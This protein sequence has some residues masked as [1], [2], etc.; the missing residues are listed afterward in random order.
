MKHPKNIFIT[1]ATG[2]IG[3][4]LAVRFLERGYNLKL[5]VRERDEDINRRIDRI[6]SNLLS[7]DKYNRLKEKIEAIRGDITQEN[8]GIS[9]KDLARIVGEVRDVFHFAASVSFEDGNREVLKRQNV[10]GTRNVLEFVKKLKTTN[11]HYMSTAYVA[12]QR[13]GIVYEV[14]LDKGQRFNNFYEET[15]FEAEKLVR[16]YEDKYGINTIIY[17]PTVVVGDSNTGRTSNFFGFYGLIKNLYLLLDMF[18]KDLLKEGKRSK[19]AGVSFKDG[20]FYI[21][22]RVPAI[23]N[24]TSNLVPVDYLIEVILR[25]YNQKNCYGKT[26]HIINPNPPTIGHIKQL[27]CHIMRISGVKIIDPDEFYT[28]PR[29]SLEELFSESIKPY[30]PYLEKEEPIFSSRN[31]QEFLG[32]NF[33]KCPYITEQLMAKL[34]SFCLQAGWGKK[35]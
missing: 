33:I 28:K 6:F 26:F 34:I 21:P 20:I 9:Q 10:D 7:M 17:R 27:I 35:P 29:S 22:L 25:L 14:E 30:R 5:L 12:G 19:A 31:T 18:K 15:K 23:A 13:K 3:S 32:D 16:E 8:L 4:S 2:F 11:L 24:K 1:G